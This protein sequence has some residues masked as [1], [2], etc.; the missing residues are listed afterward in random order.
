MLEYMDSKH[1]DILK[2]IKE[3]N[4]ISDELE[5]KMLKAL[6]DFKGIFQPAV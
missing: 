1:A 6:D 3:K 5:Q 4:A 2:E